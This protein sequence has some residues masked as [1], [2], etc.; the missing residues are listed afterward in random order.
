MCIVWRIRSFCCVDTPS[1]THLKI[2]AL[3]KSPI[4][5]T[6]RIVSFFFVNSTSSHRFMHLINNSIVNFLKDY[7]TPLK[8]IWEDYKPFGPKV[9]QF[10]TT[11]FPAYIKTKSPTVLGKEGALSITLNAS[12]LSHLSHLSVRTCFCFFENF[13]TTLTIYVQILDL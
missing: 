6:Q 7:S 12:K 11:I 4:L 2:T 8:K 1:V 13:I 5:G 3:K 10:L 9:V